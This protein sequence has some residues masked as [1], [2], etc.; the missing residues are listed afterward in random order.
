MQLRRMSIRHTQVQ[1]VDFVLSGKRIGL[2]R[3]F[4]V[5][6]VAKKSLERFS[7]FLWWKK[8]YNQEKLKKRVNEYGLLIDSCL[9]GVD[10]KEKYIESITGIDAQNNRVEGISVAPLADEIH[11]WMG[12]LQAVLIKYKVA[13]TIA[14][15]PLLVGIFGSPYLGI[16]WNLLKSKF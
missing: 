11:G 16:V 3:N 2:T 10:G 9:R 12:F 1:T 6:E 15:I 7:R 5:E 8:K 14:I 4:F 13:W